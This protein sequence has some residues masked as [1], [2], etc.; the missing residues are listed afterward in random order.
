MFLSYDMSGII[1]LDINKVEAIKSPSL[2]E[3]DF[4][5]KRGRFRVGSQ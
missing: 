4:R 2:P 3:G 1:L 5:R